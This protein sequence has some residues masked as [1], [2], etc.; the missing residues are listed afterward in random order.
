MYPCEF[1][2]NPPIGSLDRAKTT[3]YADA[4]VDLIA[5]ADRIRTKRICLPPLWAGGH[6]TI[7]KL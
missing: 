2:Q 1:A 3:R 7:Q 5:D 6:N 4:N